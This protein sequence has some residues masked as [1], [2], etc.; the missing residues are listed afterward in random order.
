[1]TALILGVLSCY[2][3]LMARSQTV[4]AA[5]CEV[6]TEVA[7]NSKQGGD[8]RSGLSATAKK[9][10]DEKASAT[11]NRPKYHTIFGSHLLKVECCYGDWTEISE[12]QEENVHGW[13]PAKQL[14]RVERTPDGKRIHVESD[15]DWIEGIGTSRYKKE[16]VVILNKIARENEKCVKLD[17]GSLDFTQ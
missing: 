14:R 1:M 11:M 5:D 8:L 15:F 10:L 17:P 4:V 12:P 2:G 3:F 7:V 16:L 13:L 9:V 6:G